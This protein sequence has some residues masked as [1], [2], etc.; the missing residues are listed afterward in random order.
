MNAIGYK[1]LNHDSHV[2]GL[3]LFNSWQ[4]S[5]ALLMMENDGERLTGGIWVSTFL[6]HKGIS[7]AMI[8]KDS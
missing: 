7:D 6:R 4:Y 3:G 8:Y 1:C 5:T 2:G